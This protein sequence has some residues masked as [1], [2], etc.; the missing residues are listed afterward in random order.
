MT[1]HKHL[2]SCWHLSALGLGGGKFHWSWEGLQPFL[3][4][5]ALPAK[6]S[7]ILAVSGCSYPAHS[8]QV[9]SIPDEKLEI[10]TDAPPEFKP[11]VLP[12]FT[13]V[14]PAINTDI[15]PYTH[16]PVINADSIYQRVL[17]CYPHKSKWKIDVELRG[18]LSTDDLA[19]DAGSSIGRNYAQIVASMPLYSA[20]EM[21]RAVKNEHD[22]R[23]E[24]AKTVAQY[25]KAIA[26]RNHAI[27]EISLFTSL[28][29]RSSVRVQ[30]GVVAATEQ[31]GY[32]QKVATAHENKIM[33]EADIMTSRL[34][35]SAM[36]AGDKYEKMNTYLTAL[37]RSPE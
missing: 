23:Q 26:E 12:T 21:D 19:Y 17:S 34:A 33:A 8:E 15:E 3:K 11:Y 32:L 36:C 22:L 14:E 35:L 24:T 4:A 30:S 10:A 20:K 27:R 9:Q 18:A 31:V 6:I 25:V 5:V 16:A 13:G 29:R 37:A 1:E 2:Y 7:L 28:E